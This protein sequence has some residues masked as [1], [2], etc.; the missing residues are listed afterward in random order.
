MFVILYNNDKSN[1]STCYEF[2]IYNKIKLYIQNICTTYLH[3]INKNV[4]YKKNN[5]YVHT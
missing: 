3:K 4:Y 2:F 1:Y 5:K